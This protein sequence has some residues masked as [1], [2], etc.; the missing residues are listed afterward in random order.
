MKPPNKISAFFDSVLRLFAISAGV[1]II[2]LTV[3]ISIGIITRYFF[4]APIRGMV[5]MSEY[6]LLWVTFLVAAWVLKDDGHI[7]MDLVLNMLRPKVRVLLNI[8]TS[9]LAT[10]T[11]MGLTYYSGKEFLILYRT[12]FYQAVVLEI[13]KAYVMVIIPVGS[14]LLFI[15]L[16]RKVCGLLRE[17]KALS[18]QRNTF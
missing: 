5:E 17:L 18:I 1:I 2:L 8:I 4:N 7:K 12:G 9:I 14:F 10:V 11:I 13:P 6:S 16:L 15:Q 3:V